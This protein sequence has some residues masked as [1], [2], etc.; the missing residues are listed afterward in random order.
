MDNYSEESIAIHLGVEVDIG[1]NNDF[2]RVFIDI[3]ALCQYRNYC[4]ALAW[5]QIGLMQLALLNLDG[6]K[7]QLVW[8]L[9]RFAP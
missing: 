5:L 8:L 4:P 1:I 7:Y 9:V 3:F 2:V 6:H